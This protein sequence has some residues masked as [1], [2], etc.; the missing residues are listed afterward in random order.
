MTSIQCASIAPRGSR[1]PCRQADCRR[2]TRLRGLIETSPDGANRDIRPVE[3]EVETVARAIGASGLPDEFGGHL[4]EARGYVPLRAGRRKRPAIPRRPLGGHF[5]PQ[6]QQCW[7]QQ[8]SSQR[9]GMS[10]LLP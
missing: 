3:Y 4:R 7:S 10:V 9:R 8:H 6:P 5:E 2:P 1:G